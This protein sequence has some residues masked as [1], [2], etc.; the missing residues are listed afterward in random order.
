MNKRLLSV[1]AIT[2]LL[3]EAVCMRTVDA[4]HDLQTYAEQ[5]RVVADDL[6]KYIGGELKRAF[7]IS[8]PLRAIKVCKYSVPELSSNM[9]RRTGWRVTR[10]SLRPRNPTLGMADSWEQSVLRKFD[11]RAALGVPASSL[12]YLQVVTEPSGKYFRYMKAL[13]TGKFCLPCHG[14]TDQ[15]SPAV[16]AQL[17]LEYPHDKATGYRVGEIRGAVSVKR[18]LE[19]H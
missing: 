9:A 4:A 12:E 6:V 8:G 14:P 1:A 13:P 2:L 18:A 5:A 19:K 17:E 15:L 11:Q 16:R 7:Q 3:M 10:V